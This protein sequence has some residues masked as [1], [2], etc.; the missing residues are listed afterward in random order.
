MTE[1]VNNPAD[2]VPYTVRA[3][4]KRY[5]ER[6]TANT[7]QLATYATWRAILMTAALT[8]FE[9]D[10]LPEGIDPRYLEL[11]LLGYGSAAIT[12]TAANGLFVGRFAQIGQGDVYQNPVHVRVIAPNGFQREGW[13]KAHAENIRGRAVL[14]PPDTCVCFDS[15]SRTSMLPA[16]DLAARRLSTY[17]AVAD[18]QVN[19]SRTPY[20]ISVSEEGKRNATEVF[21]KINDGE[22]AVMVSPQLL[23]N[24]GIQVL[25]LLGAGSY[26]ADKILNDRQKIISDVYTMLGIDNNAAAEKKERVQTSETLAN[27]EQFMIQRNAALMPRRQFANAVNDMYGLDVSVRFS[28]RHVQETAEGDAMAGAGFEREGEDERI[29]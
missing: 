15:L 17:D 21:N 26:T 27:S 14:L 19:A 18:Q 2:M 9:W 6:Y 11:I 1:T 4:G 20:L 29:S 28:V 8:R 16:I 3:F 10:G 25:Q 24:V 22:P 12:P 7:K 13:V 5:M 23:D